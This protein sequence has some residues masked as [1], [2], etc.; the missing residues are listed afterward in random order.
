MVSVACAGSTTP[1]A[2]PVPVAPAG[3]TA[4]VADVNTV[5]ISA[6]A[7]EVS[8]DTMTAAHRA[9]QVAMR[10]KPAS[11][12]NV[13]LSLPAWT[14]G[15]YQIANFAKQVTDFSA[16]AG[17]DSLD[18]DKIDHDTWRIPVAGSGEVTVRFAFK[19]DSLD[20]AWSW[21]KDDFAFFNGT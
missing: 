16:A 3:Q 10:F 5:P 2:A 11:A 21:S 15:A 4:T 14:P 20:N 13:A 19:A 18:W 12:G 8:F 17:T 1:P 6:I 7:Y 9:I